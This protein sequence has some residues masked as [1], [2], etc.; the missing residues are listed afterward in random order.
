MMSVNRYRLRTLAKAGNRGAKLAEALLART[1]SLLSVI[2]LGNNLVN[3]AAASLVTVIAFR[4]F[5]ESEMALTLATLAVTFMILVFSEVT[6]KVIG[7]TYPERIVPVVSYLLALLQKA[8]SPLIWI[9]NALVR[10]QLRLFRLAPEE[11][12]LKGAMGVEEL[13][14]LLAESGSFLPSRHRTLLLN[15][16][17]LEKLTVDDAMRPR[18]E[19]ESID[20]DDEDD[21][22]VQRLSTSL[23]AHLPAFRG[24]LNEVVGIIN[25]H[26]ALARLRD[27]EYDPEAFIEDMRAPY[28]I[29]SG[30]P[31][32]T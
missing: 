11:G 5:G 6:P 22:I 23:H 18:G 4:L 15:L 8:L 16:F 2:L 21:A 24:E 29:P 9:I 26:H 10:G 12:S 19:I 31:V 1:D 28:F 3:V 17:D 7:A 27:S 14:T 20:L 32:R 25:V 30:T 13:R